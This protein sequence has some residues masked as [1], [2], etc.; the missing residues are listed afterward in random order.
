MHEHVRDQL[1]ETEIRP[2]EEV[3]SQQI[4]QVDVPGKKDQ[5]SQVHQHIYDQQVFCYGRYPSHNDDFSCLCKTGAK[6]RKISV[7]KQKKGGN[8]FFFHEF[9]HFFYF[10]V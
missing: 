1:I 7:I 5:H 10:F 3:Q 4:V 9:L 8:T 6:V 2:H